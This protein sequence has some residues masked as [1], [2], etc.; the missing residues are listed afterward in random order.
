MKFGPEFHFSGENHQKKILIKIFSGTPFL[1]K[2][3]MAENAYL[4]L[5]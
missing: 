4:L 5:T 2:F 1:L 3:V